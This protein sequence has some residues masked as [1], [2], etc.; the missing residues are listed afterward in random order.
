MGGLWQSLKQK[1]S[2]SRP[3]RKSKNFDAKSEPIQPVEKA[4]SPQPYAAEPEKISKPTAES[5]GLKAANPYDE[6]AN[7]DQSSGTEELSTGIGMFN[8]M[9]SV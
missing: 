3:D 9:S 6:R 8:F 4:K 2:R 5:N 1:I 7:G